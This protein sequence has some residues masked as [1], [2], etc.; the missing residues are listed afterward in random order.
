MVTCEPCLT[1][2]LLDHGW[3][4]IPLHIFCAKMRVSVILFVCLDKKGSQQLAPTKLRNKTTRLCVRL[5]PILSQTSVIDWHS[6]RRSFFFNFHIP[7]SVIISSFYFAYS[8]VYLQLQ[9]PVCKHTFEDTFLVFSKSCPVIK[10][11]S[12]GLRH[13]SNIFF[14]LRYI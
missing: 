14:L 7:A 4:L 1:V 13:E 8:F 12:Y 10:R 9:T 11:D 2:G 5:C 3:A 6:S